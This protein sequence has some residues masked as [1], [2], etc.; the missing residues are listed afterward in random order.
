MNLLLKRDQ[1]G[2]AVFS[3]IPLRIGS[4]VTF[5]LHA[6]LE[7]DEEERALIQKY[8]FA[9]A[10]LVLSDAIE[11]LKQSF[12]PA[13]LL[14]LVA[15]FFIWLVGSFTAGLML[16]ILVTLVMTGVY[17]KTLREQIIVSELME[18]GRKFRCDSI[19]DLIKKEAFLLDIC[20]G[21][22]QVL[23]SAKNWH[24]RE[25]IPIFPLSKEEARLAVLRAS[26]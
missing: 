2:S 8:N 5:S 6:T 18:G 15:F 11:D 4:G 17:F 22:R 13:L 23:E 25:V 10:A 1:S 12:R 24:D 21:L 26:A 16:G 7:L 14:G 19:V 3:L 20:G 9:K